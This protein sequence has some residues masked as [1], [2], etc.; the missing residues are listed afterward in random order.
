VPFPPAHILIGAGAAE[1][2]GGGVRRPAWWRVWGVAAAF[3]LLP[4]VDVALR[5]ATGAWGPVDRSFTHSLL[6]VGVAALLVRGVAGSRWSLIAATAYGSHLMADLL[7]TQSRT[8]VVL[9][10]PFQDRGMAP[11]A[12]LFPAVPVERGAGMRQAALSLLEP[13]ALAALL[14]ETAI[15]AA[16]LLACLAIAAALRRRPIAW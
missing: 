15:G 10:W 3:A 6:A 2:A 1:L 16:V 8:S 14:I 4:D 11:L 5:A 12:H 13:P 9:V 7:Q